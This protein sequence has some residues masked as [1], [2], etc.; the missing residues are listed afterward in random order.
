MSGWLRSQPHLA[1]VLLVG[2]GAHGDALKDAQRRHAIHDARAVAVVEDARSLQQGV[3]SAAGCTASESK[4]QMKAGCGWCSTRLG[5]AKRQN[6]AA[7][8]LVQEQHCMQPCR[9]PGLAAGA[10]WHVN[11]RQDEVRVDAPS[12]GGCAGGVLVVL[13]GCVGHSFPVH[14]HLQP[15]EQVST[16]RGATAVGAASLKCSNAVQTVRLAARKG[17]HCGRMPVCSVC[18]GR[19]AAPL[20]TKALQ[21]DAPRRR[22]LSEKGC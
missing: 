10:H 8:L 21:K 22:A 13:C 3:R 14:A 11:G 9:P 5:A 6:S 20:S 4:G 15:V 2:V 19:G 7:Q 1:G 17:Q 16:Q 18:C 12:A